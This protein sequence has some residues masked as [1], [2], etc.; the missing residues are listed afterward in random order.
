MALLIRSIY[1]QCT[2]PEK[3]KMCGLLAANY[4]HCEIC[5]YEGFFQHLLSLCNGALEHSSL[6]RQSLSP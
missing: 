5:T 1:P 6:N 3:M 2:S 4:T